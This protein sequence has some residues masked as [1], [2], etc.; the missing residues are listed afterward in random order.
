MDVALYEEKPMSEISRD[1]KTYASSGLRTAT[2]WSAIGREVEG[3]SE[4][5]AK[6]DWRGQTIEFF[7]RDQTRQRSSRR[8]E[9]GAGV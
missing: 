1:L 8:R 4:A 2:D 5:R 9:A 7:S 3:G 6:L